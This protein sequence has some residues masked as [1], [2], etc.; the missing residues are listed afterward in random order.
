MGGQAD[1][2]DNDYLTVAAVKRAVATLKRNNAAPLRTA[3]V[4]GHHPPP[5]WPTT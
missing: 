5:M 2:G 4:C 1:Y 3:V